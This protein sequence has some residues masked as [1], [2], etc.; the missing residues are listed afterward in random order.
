[1]WQRVANGIGH[2]NGCCTPFNSGFKDTTEVVP[3]AAGGI[4]GRKF[5]GGAEIA[6]VGYHS[7]HSLKYFFI[8]DFQLMCQVNARSREKDMDHWLFG[9]TD[10]FP[11]GVNITDISSG[12]PGDGH[13]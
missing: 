10:S 12:K 8:A 4:L 1:M 9:I 5:D 3:L 6:R 7:L 11:R 2:V 13:T